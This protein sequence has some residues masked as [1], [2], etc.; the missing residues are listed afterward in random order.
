M[1]QRI[2]LSLFRTEDYQVPTSRITLVNSTT[3]FSHEFANFRE[4]ILGVI[5]NLLQHVLATLEDNTK[6]LSVI[7]DVSDRKGMILLLSFILVNKIQM[8]CNFCLLQN[9]LCKFLINSQ[10]KF[11]YLFNCIEYVQE[12]FPSRGIHGALCC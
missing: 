10:V 9:Y 11:F 1:P 6:V 2:L 5:H 12:S 8:E 3:E 4:K 7:I